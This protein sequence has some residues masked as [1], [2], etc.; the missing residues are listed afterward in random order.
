ML[1]AVVV[2]GFSEDEA[3]VFL[4]LL[5]CP[6]GEAARHLDDVGLGIPAIDA[7]R[8]ELE[9]LARVVFVEAALGGGLACVQPA[10]RRRRRAPV[11]EVDQH[12]RAVGGGLEQL[13]ET[14][15]RV[16]PHDGLFVLGQERGL[17][18]FSGEDVE[19]VEPEVDQLFLQLLFRGDGAQE[20]GLRELRDG[21]ETGSAAR[22][23]ERLAQLFGRLLFGRGRRRLVEHVAHALLA[24]AHLALRDQ[25]LDQLADGL[26]QRGKRD[27]PLV[28]SAVVDLPGMQLLLEPGGDAERPHAR[29]VSLIRAERYAREDVL[30][31]LGRR[32]SRR[33]LKSGFAR[34]GFRSFRGDARRHVLA[35]ASRAGGRQHGTEQGFPHH[36][37]EHD[38]GSVS[39][40]Q[41]GQTDRCPIH[42]LPRQPTVSSQV[43]GGATGASFSARPRNLTDEKASANRVTWFPHRLAWRAKLPRT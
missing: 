25:G 9:Q 5:D 8:V 11:V 29:A 7:E 33:I 3:R 26:L 27:Q 18:V 14:A 28:E 31:H 22:L 17:L 36:P 37:V 42:P 30:G 20:L 21:F 13:G 43:R 19:M 15:Q 38:R 40:I 16:R 24:L 39:E 12:R 1:L 35:R 34:G 2:Q 23:A 6:A 10:R 4:R 32:Q 41:P